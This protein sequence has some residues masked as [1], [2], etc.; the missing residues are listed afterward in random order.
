M[1]QVPR[2]PAASPAVVSGLLVCLLLLSA[3]QAPL[4]AG[5]ITVDDI[6]Q[7]ISVSSTGFG[8][9]SISYGSLLQQASFS[10]NY[11]SQDPLQ[12][13]QSVTYNVVF[14]VPSPNGSGSIDSAST[15]VTITSLSNP[16]LT[17]N[18]SV[19]V[20]FEGVVTE[21]I[22]PGP[23]VYFLT[24]PGG[25]FDVTAYLRG[26]QA[27]DVPTDLTVLIASASVPEPSSLTLGGIA[28]LISLGVALRR[29]NGVRCV[30]KLLWDRSRLLKK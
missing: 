6:D 14:Q 1:F 29:R 7:P 17:Q 3:V 21:P 4:S 12:P 11:L 10:G 30:G 8:T 16:T 18:T 23:G 15:E 25:F 9:T 26:Q 5:T 13:G 20:F 19:S 22:N 27:P 24:A 2:H 28:A